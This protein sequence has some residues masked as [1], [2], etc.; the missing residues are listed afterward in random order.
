MRL[1]RVRLVLVDKR[2]AE[3]GELD[4][5]YVTNLPR[6]SWTADAISAAYRPRWLIERAFRR[7]K[8]GARA[9]HLHTSRETSAMALLG[10]A[11]LLVS[12]W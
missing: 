4:R 8:H 3:S 10:A 5:W 11:L 1:V 12:G 7:M 9:D 6:A 2:G